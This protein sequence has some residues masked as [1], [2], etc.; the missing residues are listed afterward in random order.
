[1]AVR[2][3][4]PP[5][6]SA[7]YAARPRP[8]AAR[9]KTAPRSPRSAPHAGYNLI[10]HWG[11]RMRHGI[12]SVTSNVD[13]H[14]RRK[15]PP[16]AGERQQLEEFNGSCMHWRCASK[17]CAE[18]L[19]YREDPACPSGRWRVPPGFRFSVDATTHLAA[20]GPPGEVATEAVGSAQPHDGDAFVSNHPRCVVCGGVARPAVKMFQDSDTWLDAADSGRFNEFLAQLEEAAEGEES[21]S[22]SETEGKRAAAAAP[23]VP[24]PA[25]KAVSTAVVLEFGCGPNVRT[26][27]YAASKAQMTLREGVGAQQVTLIRV[28][29]EYPLCEHALS[30]GVA[31]IPLLEGA[32][33]ATQAIDA[34]IPS[35]RE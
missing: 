35:L 26:M 34:L 11:E 32:L 22:E 5:T 20:A 10:K 1:M 12:F 17:K 21:S 29:P 13:G 19:K 14:W 25:P 31:F 28:N 4:W 7:I 3:P 33:E 15:L 23:R 16:P 18:T 24:A 2:D 6:D 30:P 27:R 8:A 9:A